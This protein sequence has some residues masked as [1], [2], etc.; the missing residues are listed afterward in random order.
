MSTSKSKVFHR[1]GGYFSLDRA[2]YESPAFRSLSCT[3]RSV[4]LDLI[5]IYVPGKREAIAMSARRLAANIGI[6]KDTAAKS[7]RRLV[8][9][10]LIDVV[11]ESMWIYGRARA[12]RLTFKNYKGRLPS[13]DWSKY[14]NDDPN[15]SDGVS[16]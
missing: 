16:G 6:N 10:G 1:K 14:Q 3:D 11:S 8:K 12:Y 7:L 2:V 5:C 9:V 13:D 4:L 15:P